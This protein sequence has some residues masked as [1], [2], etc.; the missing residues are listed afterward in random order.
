MIAAGKDYMACDHARNQGTCNNR[1][2]IKR[3][4]IEELVLDTLKSR[5]MAPHL[6]EEFIRAFHAEV[7]RMEKERNV[8]RKH[9]SPQSPWPSRSPPPWGPGGSAGRYR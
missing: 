7:N 1:R 8:G 9:C 4:R 3:E 6:V 5:L 2:G